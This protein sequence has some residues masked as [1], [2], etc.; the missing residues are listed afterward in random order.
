MELSPDEYLKNAFKQWLG[1]RE[2]DFDYV[3]GVLVRHDWV[4]DLTR[5]CMRS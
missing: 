2:G 1:D 4:T 5:E 3:D